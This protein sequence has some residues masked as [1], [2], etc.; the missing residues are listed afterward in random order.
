MAQEIHILNV[1]LPDDTIKWI[2]ALVKQGVY[3]S[4]SEAIRDFI[5]DHLKEGGR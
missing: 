4:R 2:D 5:R 1:R 3:N